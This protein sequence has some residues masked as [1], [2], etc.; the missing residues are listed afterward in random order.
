MAAD[1]VLYGDIV[2]MH[3][4]SPRAQA[5]AVT[6]GRITAVARARTSR[7]WWGGRIPASSTSE[8]PLFCR[9]VH[10]TARSPPGRSHRSRA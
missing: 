5:L 6:G 4:E 10:R 9:G 8:V 2:T 7:N 3:E 1:L